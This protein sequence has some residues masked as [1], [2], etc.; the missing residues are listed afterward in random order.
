MSRGFD[1]QER[2]DIQHALVAH[3]KELF[4]QFGFQKTSIREIAK[5]TGIAQGTFYHFFDSKEELYFHI[6]ES[7]EQE[8]REQWMGVDIFAA[9]QPK[10][11][12]KTILQ[13][14]VQTMETNPFIRELYFDQTVARLAKKLSPEKLDQHFQADA[15]AIVPLM[16]ALEE[17][18]WKIDKEPAVIAGM[19]RS[20]FVLALHQQEI[21]TDVYQETMAAFIDVMVEGLIREEH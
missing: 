6:L 5:R 4:R 13:Q 16:K 11:A 8:M 2:Q 20:L 3:G 7:E 21:G 15:T 12:I 19:L 14:M 18:G 10:R 9:S 1:E 17:K